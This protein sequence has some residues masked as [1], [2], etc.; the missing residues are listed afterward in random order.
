MKGLEKYKL[1]KAFTKGTIIYLDSAPHVEF[2]VKLPS[3]Y[4]RGYTQGLYGAMDFSIDGEGE[5]KAGG[6]LISAKY[7]QEDAFLD[8]CLVSIDGEPVPKEFSVEYPEA[9]QELMSKATELAN[10]ITE[11]VDDSV[12]KS[13]ASS[14][15]SET[16]EAKKS[17]M[18]TLKAGAV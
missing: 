1:D 13:S 5:V 11:R 16:G 17:S 12:K 10:A 7:A 15:G 14:D 9:L 8:H 6:G 18:P 4:N 3:P 2:L